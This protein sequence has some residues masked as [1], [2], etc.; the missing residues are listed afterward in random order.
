MGGLQFEHRED[1]SPEF[2]FVKPQSLKMGFTL[3]CDVDFY[4]VLGRH[5]TE[6]DFKTAEG[7]ISDA[8]LLLVEGVGE[9]SAVKGKVYEELT[10]GNGHVLTEYV[11]DIHRGGFVQERS[12]GFEIAKAKCIHANRIPVAQLDPGSNHKAAK[13][14]EEIA[15]NPSL[16][17]CSDAILA[18]NDL[19]RQRDQWCLNN[20]QK[21]VDR[22]LDYVSGERRRVVITRGLMHLRLLR[23]LEFQCEFNQVKANGSRVVASSVNIL[24]V[25]GGLDNILF[26][27]LD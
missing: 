22:N 13:K 27:E 25:D 3:P 2:D 5:R 14:S 21:I 4:V 18:L 9:A 11:R 10:E 17:S 23:A 20:L 6:E 26:G 1:L 24:Y 15:R 16:M 19:G 8:D 7:F 12:R